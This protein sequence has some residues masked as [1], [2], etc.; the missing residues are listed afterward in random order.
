MWVFCVWCGHGTI[1]EPRSLVAKVKD[2][3]D[4]IEAFEKRLTCSKCGRVGVRLTDRP[5]MS[6]QPHGG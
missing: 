5:I 1:T 6:F 2:A 4:L 3:P